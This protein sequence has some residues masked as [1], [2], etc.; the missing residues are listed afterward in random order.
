MSTYKFLSKA[1][2]VPSRPV[3]N[4]QPYTTPGRVL[5]TLKM[6]KRLPT[7]IDDDS[8]YRRL[9]TGEVVYRSIVKHYLHFLNAGSPIHFSHSRESDLSPVLGPVKSQGVW[10]KEEAWTLF[11]MLPCG[12]PKDLFDSETPDIRVLCETYVYLALVLF[13]ARMRARALKIL[14]THV[15]PESEGT[16]DSIDT[17]MTSMLARLCAAHRKVYHVD[18]VKHNTDRS[19]YYLSMWSSVCPMFHWMTRRRQSSNV[20]HLQKFKFFHEISEDLAQD[21]QIQP[22][23][24]APSYGTRKLKFDPSRIVLHYANPDE[25]KVIRSYHQYCAVFTDG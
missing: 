24:E 14:L 9:V 17:T 8:T 5:R 1:H 25:I 6:T 20:R 15:P 4:G 12:G 16:K 18:L 10:S 22:F 23:Y 21:R 7:K 3:I 2:S 19:N 11:A 13:P